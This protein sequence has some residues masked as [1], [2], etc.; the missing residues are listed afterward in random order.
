MRTG[1]AQDGRPAACPVAQ[2]NY[3]S[4]PGAAAVQERL[5]KGLSVGGPATTLKTT[6]RA[7][8]P[9]HHVEQVLPR[10]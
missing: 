1:R 5:G 8:A 6:G 3:H 7:E 9:G 10:P 4:E 2:G